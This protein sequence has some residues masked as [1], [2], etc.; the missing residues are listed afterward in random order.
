MSAKP[1]QF[2]T[3]KPTLP[4]ADDAPPTSP[5]AGGQPASTRASGTDDRTAFTWRLYPQQALMFDDLMYRAKR[6]LGTAKLD[7]ATVLLALVRAARES[8]GVYGSLLAQLQR[9]TPPAE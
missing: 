6:D 2:R 8:P 9:E 4:N 7:K 3:I 5:T 1:K